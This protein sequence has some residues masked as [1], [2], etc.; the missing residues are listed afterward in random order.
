MKRTTVFLDEVLIR[1]ARQVA[2]RAGKSFAAVI[3]EA[4]AQYVAGGRPGNRKL[5]SVVGMFD[6]GHT[7]TSERVDELLWRD[8]H[9]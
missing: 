2:A 6:S 4:V 9:A 3:R 5:P 8:P 7:D 1:K